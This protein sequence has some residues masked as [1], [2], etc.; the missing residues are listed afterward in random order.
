MIYWIYKNKTAQN[1][2]DFMDTCVGV[3]PFYISQILTYNGLE[4]TNRLLISKKGS[5]CMMP[6]KI[7][8]KCKEHNVE[9]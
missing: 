9:H 7:D 4:F 8:V 1:T 3:S 5:K 2:A 6:S